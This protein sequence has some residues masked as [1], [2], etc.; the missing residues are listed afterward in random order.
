MPKLALS[1]P[2]H[3]NQAIYGE[4]VQHSAIAFWVME[5]V[6]NA[7]EP[8]CIVELGT[9]M[10]GMSMY[11]GTWAASQAA[12]VLTIDHVD[13]VGKKLDHIIRKIGVQRVVGDIFSDEAVSAI[14]AFI[15]GKE[16]LVYCDG[17]NKERELAVFSTLAPTVIG[18]HDYG[19]EVK[20]GTINTF[21]SRSGYKKIL[22]SKGVYNTLQMFW[23]RSIEEDIIRSTN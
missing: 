7:Y 2:E 15:E 1:N 12:H 10:G 6:L 11:L 20:S 21:L 14:A 17:G 4:R 16:C 23:E 5:N 9:G 19:T 8:E 22:P 3:V 18:C 13:R